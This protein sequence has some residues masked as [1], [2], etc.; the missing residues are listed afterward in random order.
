MVDKKKK[1]PSPKSANEEKKTEQDQQE[2]HVPG[3]L[4]DAFREG[5]FRKGAEN[6]KRNNGNRSKKGGTRTEW[7]E[8]IQ[9]Q[10]SV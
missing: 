1:I 10:D 7:M 8:L 3:V 2:R 9:K 6:F 5:R 4:N